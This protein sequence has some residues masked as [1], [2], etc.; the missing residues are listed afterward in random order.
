MTL[1]W[2]LVILAAILAIG[3][4]IFYLPALG[5]NDSEADARA[6][7]T[8]YLTAVTGGNDDRGW[9]LLEGSGRAEY[10]S[11][12]AYRR[13]MAAADWSRFAWE[14][15]DGHCDDGVCTLILRLPNG[16][17]SIPEEAWSDGPGDPGIL[18]ATKEEPWGASLAAINVLQRGWFGG[19]GVV[20]FGVINSSG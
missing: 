5:W 9:A 6:R 7:A 3:A 8:A 13:L 4:G 15:A 10:A 14:V 17:S 20:V 11:E 12:E 2:P 19:I 16:R 18:V 1:R